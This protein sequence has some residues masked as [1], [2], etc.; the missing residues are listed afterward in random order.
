M[1][2]VFFIEDIE[3]DCFKFKIFVVMM[4]GVRDVYVYVGVV[5]VND[6]LDLGVFVLI[7]W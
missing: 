6:W 4:K 5:V 2:W 7:F 3:F 1:V